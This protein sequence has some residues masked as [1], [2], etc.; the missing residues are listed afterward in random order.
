MLNVLSNTGVSQAAQI[1]AVIVRL[2][3]HL[4]WLKTAVLK[5]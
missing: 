5:K 3:I 2:N 1:V 4:L